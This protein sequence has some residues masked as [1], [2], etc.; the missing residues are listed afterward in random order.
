MLDKLILAIQIAIYLRGR[1]MYIEDILGINHEKKDNF[2]NSIY[3]Y[4]R[5]LYFKKYPCYFWIYS[6]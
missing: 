1:F 2:I 5:I 6:D 4:F 3:S